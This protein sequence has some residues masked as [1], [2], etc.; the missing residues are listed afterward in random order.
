[1]AKQDIFGLRTIALFEAAKG[2]LVIVAGLGLVAFLHRDAQALAESII[3]RLHINP[4]SRYPTI[5]LALLSHPSDARLWA[6]GGSAAVYALMRFAEAWGLWHRLA[7]GNWL[8]VFSGGIY[9]PLELYEALVHPSWMHAS[10]AVAN[11]LVV[12]YLVKGL[13]RHEVMS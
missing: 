13:A 8:G 5:F 10:L 12:L 7:W 2:A 11:L 1:M 6:I 3:M 4:A 9:L